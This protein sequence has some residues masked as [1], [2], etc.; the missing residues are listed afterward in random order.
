MYKWHR[1]LA[2]LMAVPMTLWMLSGVLHPM[3]SNWFKP[4]IENKFLIKPAISVEDSELS[5]SVIFSDIEKLHMVKL[6]QIEDR[7]VLM[8]ISPD[9]ERHYRDAVTG[10]K[11]NSGEEQY[12]EQLARAYMND[13]N[14]PL[15][16]IT[17]IASFD[18]GY[19]YIHRFLPVYR[20][21]LDREDDLQVVIDPRTGKLAAYDNQFRRV[22]SKLFS[23][24]HTW[25][26]LGS[27]DSL[28]RIGVVSFLSLCG[29]FIALSGAISLWTMR[30]VKR[31]GKKA[32]RTHYWLGAVTSLLFFMFSLSGFFHVVVKFDYDDSDQWVSNQ[33]VDTKDLDCSISEVLTEAGPIK[34]LSLAVIDEK[35]HFRIVKP[36]RDS[37][38]V[39]FDL[40]SKSSLEDGDERYAKQLALEFSEYSSSDIKGT[41][42]ITKFRNDYGFIFRRLPVWRVSFKDKEYWSYTVDTQDAHMALRVKP[43]TVIEA[44]SFVNLHKFHFIDPLGK[45]LR[46]WVLVVS[47]GLMLITVFSGVLLMIRRR[48]RSVEQ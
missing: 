35:P 3:M 5:V 8:G 26:F 36:G 13:S 25:S 12:V 22:S 40:S 46:D 38:V 33:V 39:M 44:I 14:S 11:I 19:S 10:E 47:V 6:I 32:R 34:E 9:Q 48:K 4:E 18:A 24:L 1:R 41:E 20:V 17:K 37:S 23:W 2:W 30:K 43:M 42:K 15:V 29:F 21:E 27:R 31:K 28:F 16:S 7:P 45:S